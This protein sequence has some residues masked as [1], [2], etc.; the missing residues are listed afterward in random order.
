MGVM[1]TCKK[2]TYL[3]SLATAD[4][5]LGFQTVLVT[6]KDSLGFPACPSNVLIVLR[7]YCDPIASLTEEVDGEIGWLGLGSTYV[8]E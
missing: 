5:V 4:V 3:V 6:A 2:R 7:S 8:F 1:H